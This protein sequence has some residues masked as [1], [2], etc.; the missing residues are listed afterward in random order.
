M[1]HL[2]MNFTKNR[3]TSQVKYFNKDRVVCMYLT[4]SFLGHTCAE[5]IKTEFEEGIQ[6]L[7]TKKM[8]QVSMD[9]PIL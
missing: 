3:W 6:E 4:S 7:N 5:D 9:G 2:T 1:I 8:T